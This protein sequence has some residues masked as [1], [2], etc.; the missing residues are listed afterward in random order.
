MKAGN[1]TGGLTG[2]RL[3]VGVCGGIA[4]YKAAELVRLLKT[5]GAEVR[6][7]MTRA[8]TAFVAPLTFQ[9]LSGNLVHTDLFDTDAEAAMGHI[10]L[11][12][13]ADAVVITPATA[14]FIARLRSGLADDLLTTLCLA[15]EVRISLVPAMNRAMWNHPATQEN[16]QALMQRGVRLL[17]PAQGAQACG[18]IGPGRM[19]EPAEIRALLANDFRTGRLK[20][21]SVMVTA[22]PTREAIDPVRYIS[23]RSSGKMGY[24]LAA[25]AA[26]GG[27]AVT[28]ITGPVSLEVPARLAEVVRVESAR[29]MYDAVMARIAG[30]QIYL[31]AAAVADYR[32]ISAATAKIKKKDAGTLLSL[33]RTRDILAAVAALEN[34]PFTVGFAAETGDVETY[35]KAKL[36]AKR[37]DMIAAN[38]VGAERGGFESDENALEV[39]WATGRKTLAMVS[40]TQLAKQLLELV[41]ERYEAKKSRA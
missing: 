14:D 10:R 27:A 11:A 22:G 25:A 12:R 8:A 23:N 2:K 21:L 9:A 3:L 1:G 5:E 40:K 4:A 16:V 37:L 39:Y 15:A 38:R 41:A 32:P 20:G 17:G 33:E 19:L 34:A 6:V 26:E 7:V 35:A 13:W 30:Q 18:E 29:E 24:A 36:K 28:L 31:G